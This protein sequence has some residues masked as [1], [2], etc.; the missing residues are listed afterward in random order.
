MEVDNDNEPDT[1]DEEEPEQEDSEQE[2]PEQEEITDAH[3]LS[4]LDRLQKGLP[5]VYVVEPDEE[6]IHDDTRDSDDGVS[7]DLGEETDDPDYC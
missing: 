7:I 3:D 1:D 5:N 6:V 2:D 4:M